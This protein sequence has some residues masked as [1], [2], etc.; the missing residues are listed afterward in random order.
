M[1]H[2]DEIKVFFNFMTKSLSFYICSKYSQRLSQVTS[3]KGVGAKT[4]L[5]HIFVLTLFLFL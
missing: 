4:F 2:L 1:E 5:D 3:Q